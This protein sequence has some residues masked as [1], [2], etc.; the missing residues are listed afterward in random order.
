MK[1][2]ALL[3]LIVLI[4]LSS[5]VALADT[6][7]G[8]LPGWPKSVDINPFFSDMGG[9]VMANVDDDADLEIVVATSGQ[10]LWVWDVDGSLVFSASLTG[11]AQ[12]VAAV[13]DVTGDAAPEIV[14]GTRDQ[15]GGVPT[16]TL[17]VFSGGGD[18]LFSSAL[19]HTGSMD[20]PVTLADTD[21]DDK[22]EIIVAERGASTGWLHVLQG[23]LTSKSKAWPATLDHVPATS[24]AVGDIDG[25]GSPEIVVCS[26]TS[27]YAFD[28]GG[29]LLP[30]FPVTYSDE[31]YSYGAPALADLNDD[32]K[33]DILTVTHGDFNRLH[34]TGH[35][36]IELSGWPYDLGDAWSFSSPAVGDVDADGDPEVV[37]GRSGGFAED[38][39][40]FV[41][42]HNGT[43]L[44]NFPFLMLGGSE[45]NFVLA[46]LAGDAGLE[47]LFTNN[48]RE[49]GLGYL[50]MVDSTG[51]TADGW[52]LRT[53]GMTYLNGATVADANRDGTP[54]IGV[55][56]VRE[57]ATAS[58]AMYSHDGYGFGPGGVH[59]ATY[60]A[61]PQHTGL[62][63]PR[64][65][66]DDDD[67]DDDDT[68]DDDDDTADDDDDDTSGDDDSGGDD[69][70]DD[71]AGCCG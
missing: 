50:Y 63:A 55:L 39:N 16:P 46:D 41:I 23:D 10:E 29:A 1:R 38:D 52:P 32:G 11:L 17:H 22:L 40:L 62:Y 60:Q 53:D 6:Q 9:F 69:D 28:A 59:W 3:F 8:Q 26:F 66:D 57:D 37:V 51:A 70:D 5:G 21:Q 65:P 35:D 45:G 47:I 24:A 27:L 7:I 68:S 14:V 30:G 13:G 4:S 36:G 71:D 67:D 2:F 48:I 15:T 19:P 12:G 33:P 42:H 18:L 20:N 43:D 61:D 64:Y 25:D 34:A 44:D 58:I 31:T 56:G 54:E 49:A